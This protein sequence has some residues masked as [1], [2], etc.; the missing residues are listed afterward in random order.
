MRT[1][2]RVRA[3]TAGTTKGPGHFAMVPV[4]FNR[5]PSC[6]LCQGFLCGTVQTAYKRVCGSTA[7]R[8]S[9]AAGDCREFCAGGHDDG[10]RRIIT[11]RSR[12]NF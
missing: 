3:G 11:W 5:P 12:K 1:L 10:K 7:M 6:G 2:K 9:S 8:S 4:K